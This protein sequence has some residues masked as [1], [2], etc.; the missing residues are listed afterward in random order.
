MASLGR[1]SNAQQWA[2]M[3]LKLGLV[4]TDVKLWSMIDS[5]LRESADDVGEVVKEKYELARR[6]SIMVWQSSTVAAMGFS[7]RM[8]TPASAG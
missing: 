4:V 2:R 3:A 1:R 5:Q 8:W 7:H 6:A